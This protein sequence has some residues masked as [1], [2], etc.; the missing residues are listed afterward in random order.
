MWFYN[1]NCIFFYSGQYFLL[2]TQIS[3]NK[4]KHLIIVLSKLQNRD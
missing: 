4:L 1:I 3:W 2:A